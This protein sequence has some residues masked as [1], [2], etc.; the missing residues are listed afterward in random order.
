M[1][2]SS[3]SI[4]DVGHG[5]CSIIRDGDRTVVV[6]AG[7]KNTLLEFL[8][9]NNITHLET[10]L[11]SHSDEDHI[12]GLIALLEADIVSFGTVYLNS[13][14]S[15]G[16][17]LWQQLLYLLEHREDLETLKFEISLTDGLGVS[18]S[19]DNIVLEVLGPS[20]AAA[21]RG[22]GAIV[23]EGIDLDT[24]SMSAVIRVCLPAPSNVSVLLT[25]DMDFHG[26]ERILGRDKNLNSQVLVYPHHGGKAHG[27][28][29]EDFADMLLEHVKPSSVVFSF[30]R[31]RFKNPIPAIV[32]R[33]T[34]QSKDV[35]IG[36]TQLSSHCS[37][38][39]LEQADFSH[40]AAVSHGHEQK[41]CC[42][43]TMV[44][45]HS[46]SNEFFAS[47]LQHSAF[48]KN[49]VPRPLCMTNRTAQ[50]G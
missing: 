38:K 9:E 2:V 1:T 25:S 21:A 8:S 31:R 19:T 40:I 34:E 15:K 43:G 22:P 32:Q 48:I 36:C 45:S 41:L 30:G 42:A 49:F 44:F 33:I 50:G 11:L 6:D 37:M 16:S 28:T 47:D 18:L 39:D 3:I 26:L 13:D 24:N 7:S 20:K 4:L 14:A 29:P 46:Q 27:A 12:G 17:N 35:R 23:K 5:N 10:V